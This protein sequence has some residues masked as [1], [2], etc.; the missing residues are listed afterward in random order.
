VSKEALSLS[1]YF[2]Y[3]NSSEMFSS[4]VRKSFVSNG[5]ATVATVSAVWIGERSSSR[6]TARVSSNM[7][8]VAS[9]N[10]L[11]QQRAA[12]ATASARAETRKGGRSF[13]EWY[14]GNLEANPVATK[15][16]TGSILW[17]VGDAVAQIVPE[18]ASSEIRE[19]GTK[20]DWERTARAAFFGF[21]VHAPTSHLHFN[22]LESLTN[23]VGVTGLGRTF[24]KTFMEQFVYWSWLSNSMY[25]GFMG[26]MQGMTVDQIYHRIADV[27]WDTQKAQWLFWIPVQLLNFKFVPVRH[28]L[29]VVL[30][31]SVVWTAL[32]SAWYPPEEEEARSPKTIEVTEKA[33]NS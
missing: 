20:Y 6:A 17:S 26:A 28:Q 2:A 32:L 10:F 13:V 31:T 11:S 4:H 9:R 25:H 8:E 23:R 5:G 12:F 30:G 29:N 3:N 19:G 27:L 14:E 16:V 15:M 1:L 18:M 22:F 33:D 21:A 24:F 7:T